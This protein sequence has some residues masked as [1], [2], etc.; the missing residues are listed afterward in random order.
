MALAKARRNSLYES[1][2][3]DCYGAAFFGKN[4]P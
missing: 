1:I 2:L 4:N 3:N